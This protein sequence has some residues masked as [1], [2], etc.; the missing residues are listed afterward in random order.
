MKALN[1]HQFALPGMEH[2]AH[3]FA[4]MLPHGLMVEYHERDPLHANAHMLLAH[5][6][7]DPT[8]DPY[9]QSREAAGVLEWS[10]QHGGEYPGEIQ[11]VN[12][13]TYGSREGHIPGVAQAL[14]HTAHEIDLGQSTVPIHSPLR[15]REGD[16]FAEKTG[17]PMPPGEG[18]GWR[19]PKGIHPFEQHPEREGMISKMAE[20]YVR[21]K[22][23]PQLPFNDRRA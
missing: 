11:W 17:G 12:N 9:G 16:A 15:T 2:L 14:Y 7:V 10:N 13:R 19:P 8:K 21:A 5:R 1:P 20:D 6:R 18:Y 3:P 4:P 22:T 23:H